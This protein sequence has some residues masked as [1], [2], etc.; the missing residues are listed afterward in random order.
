MF[1]SIVIMPSVDIQWN[2]VFASVLLVLT[3]AYI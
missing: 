3:V 1:P 2:N